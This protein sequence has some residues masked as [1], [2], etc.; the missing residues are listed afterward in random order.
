[1]NTSFKEIIT[2]RFL[3]CL[4]VF[5]TIAA[6]SCGSENR[7]KPGRLSE[8]QLKVALVTPGSIS[9]QAWNQRAYE[10]L[11]RIRDSLG[12]QVSHVETAT[13]AQFEENFRAYGSQ[14]FDIVFGHGSEFQDAALRVS[15]EFPNTVYITTG[16]NA[17]VGNA[18]G[19]EFAFEEGSYV[20]GMVA[21]ALTKSNIVGC[22]GGTELPP[23]K[24]SFDA[25]S[26][27]AK[28]INPKVRVLISYIGN[29]DDASGGREQ[30]LAQIGRGADVIFGNADAAGLGIF[31]AARESK[32]VAVIGANA[33]QAHVAPEVVIG[34]VVIDIPHAF[35]S[36]AREI[37]AGTFKSRVVSFGTQSDVVRWVYNPAL[38]TRVPPVA[39]A[40]V[41]SVTAR[42]RAGTFAVRPGAARGP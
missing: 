4:F 8:G 18:V 35:L 10:G 23:V 9:D 6:A 15:S 40:Q 27:G 22:I 33:D 42:I 19:M 29:W 1:V 14:G 25:F 32:A 38:E 5:N 24:R 26:E 21:G 11:L 39:R 41:E 30:S 3:V 2:P 34:S 7:P 20:A 36:V 37:Q 13:P 31:R 12:A 17:A 28:A 16:G